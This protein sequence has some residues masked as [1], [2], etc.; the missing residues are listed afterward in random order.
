MLLKKIHQEKFVLLW[1]PFKSSCPNFGKN[2]YHEIHASEIKSSD[3]PLLTSEMNQ[4]TEV[5][6]E[7]ISCMALNKI[8]LVKF[9]L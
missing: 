1:L 4:I 2:C 8:S 9:I 3:L 7:E 6:F 5:W